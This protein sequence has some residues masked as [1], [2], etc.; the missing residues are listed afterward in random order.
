MDSRIRRAWYH[1]WMMR[2]GRL[3]LLALLILPVFLFF[4]HTQ[5]RNDGMILIGISVALYI[6]IFASMLT[7]EKYS[8][9]QLGLFAVI[10]GSAIYFT[11]LYLVY[12]KGQMHEWMPNLTRAMFV[13][14][15]PMFAIA[16][17]VALVQRTR[18]RRAERS[19]DV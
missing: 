7:T 14:G 11:F 19:A 2:W 10:L 16:T 1:P 13:I 8:T 6:G 18:A 3:I 12:A 4:M 5:A 15:S 17:I 9:R